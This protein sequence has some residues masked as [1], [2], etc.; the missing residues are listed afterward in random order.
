MIAI[1]G[2]APDQA[3]PVAR[4]LDRL[5]GEITKAAQILRGVPAAAF[6][7]WRHDGSIPA[8]DERVTRARAL[9]AEMH[10]PLTMSPGDVRHL[11]SRFQRGVT[12][13]LDVIDGKR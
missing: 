13:L 6:P 7:A 9:L 12:E 3:E 2:P 5:A 8:D 1:N 11:L 4:I 10:Q